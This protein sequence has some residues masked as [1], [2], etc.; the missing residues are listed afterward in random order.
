MTDMFKSHSRS[1]TSPPEHAAPIV[2]SDAAELGHLP[3][4]VYVGG[5][6]DLTVRMQ[7]G[8]TVTLAAV[9]GGTF[10]PIRVRQVFAAGTSATGIVGFW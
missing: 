4:A 2:P 7:G 1:L 9:P 10:L 5:A 3:R 6:G 8:E